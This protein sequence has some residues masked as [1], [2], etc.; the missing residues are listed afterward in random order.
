[1]VAKIKIK[2]ACQG[3]LYLTA[4]C[5]HGN[6]SRSKMRCMNIVECSSC[7][8]V[9]RGKVR[10]KIHEGAKGRPI[11]G[12][13]MFLTITE[14]TDRGVDDVLESYK[15]FRKWLW[16]EYPGCKF[17][18]VFELTKR[19]RLHIHILHDSGI[20]LVEKANK[21]GEK[22][23]PY[24]RKQSKEGRKFIE[25]LI[26]FGF[27]YII[28]NQ[29]LRYGP[30][31]A[32]SYMAKYLGKATNKVIQRPDGRSIRVAEGSRNWPT[33]K[34]VEQ[35]LFT[36]TTVGSFPPGSEQHRGTCRCRVSRR[37]KSWQEIGVETRYVMDRNRSLCRTF[38]RKSLLYLHA[39]EIH[40]ALG[41]QIQRCLR[42]PDW[43]SEIRFQFQVPYR[44]SQGEFSFP[45]YSGQSW[46]SCDGIDRRSVQ[47]KSPSRRKEEP[48]MP[49]I[50]PLPFLAYYRQLVR[51]REVYKAEKRHLRNEIGVPDKWLQK[52]LTYEVINGR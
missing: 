10:A 34:K 49:P 7:K 16:R 41:K 44:E 39:C 43:S 2:D 38:S 30:G 8:N 50:T 40:S 12:A 37:D 45:S 32:G 28:D 21:L 46:L 52:Y 1:M 3:N 9:W 6:V 33:K 23:G 25:R 42:E 13:W 17:F 35:Y 14:S 31:G 18:R 27:G 11:Y 20:P 36:N 22:E 24:L 29:P 19:G 51:M 5:I 15:K 26:N 47:K 48:S 4:K